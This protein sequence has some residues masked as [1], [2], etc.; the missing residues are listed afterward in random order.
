LSAP[1]TGDGR[2]D[3][4]TA[5]LIQAVHNLLGEALPSWI[6]SGL[7]VTATSP[8]SATVTV[9]SGKGTAGGKIYELKQNVDIPIPFDSSHY[10]FYL[11]LWD[12]RIIVDSS[13]NPK[14]LTIAKI[15]VPKP[16]ITSYI[17]NTKDNSWNAYIVM[18][19]EYKLYGDANG[20]LEE[21]SIE[22]L[23]D[24]MRYLLADNIIGNIRL[25]E[26]LKILNTEGTV[27]L[28]SQ[29]LKIKDTSENLL[30]KF[31]R[32]GVYF[33]NTSGVEMAR[34][35]TSDARVGN[36]V[37]TTNSIQS[38]NYAGGVR[39]FKIGDNGDVEFQN[40]TLRG[41]IYANYGIIGGW[42]IASTSLSSS[43]MSISSSTGINFNNL[44][45]V[46]QLGALTAQSGVI[47]GFTITATKLYGGIIQ[48]ALTV[49]A[50]SDG[51]VMDTAG[52][53]GYNATLGLVFNL[54]TDGSAPTFASGVINSTVFNINTNAVLRTSETVGDGSAL[55]YGILINNTGLYGCGPNQLVSDANLK[56]LI[57]GTIS[58]KGTITAIAG[59]IG[60]TTITSTTLTGGTIIGALIRSA[61]IETA[62]GVPKIRIDENGIYYQVS[63]QSGKYGASGSGLYGFKYG[64]GTKYGAGVTAYLL[65]VDYPILSVESEQNPADIHLYNRSAVPTAGTHRIG[66][67]I[68]ISGLL[69]RCTLGGT[70]GDFDDWIPASSGTTGGTGSAGAGKQYIQINVG[71]TIYKCLHDGTV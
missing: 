16:G 42:T 62:E 55:S 36:I 23:R 20:Y 64:D 57:D 67:L 2:S 4:S 46:S 18:F 39:G 60:G 50:G 10:V 59:T 14:R 31:N 61:I 49:G 24:N 43:F 41:T 54:P 22:F 34:F 11:S 70:P 47:G 27:E 6:I 45:T 25:S 28:D 3:A 38:G 66:D 21:D 7:A 19:R 56:A 44:F 35:T 68:C 69:K 51:V 33:Y 12:N 29:S 52:L 65:K 13:Y 15:V 58:L 71:G 37:I 30:A 17:Q 1:F 32:N 5:E 48:T 8:I 53:R 9:G 63:A 40:A 26:N